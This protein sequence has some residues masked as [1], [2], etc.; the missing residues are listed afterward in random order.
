MVKK[1]TFIFLFYNIKD[2]DLQESYNSTV[3][4]N[5]LKANY[6]GEANIIIGE[7]IFKNLPDTTKRTFETILY[8]LKPDRLK[9]AWTKEPASARV[10][11]GNINIADKDVLGLVLLYIKLNYPAKDYIL[12]TNNHSNQFGALDYDQIIFK[13]G[14]KY[15]EL[16]KRDIVIKHIYEP[17][18]NVDMLSYYEL[19][20]AIEKGFLLNQFKQEKDL[21]YCLS[22]LIN[23]GC[24]SS[25]LDNLFHFSKSGD[26]NKN[27]IKYYCGSESRIANYFVDASAIINFIVDNGI[28]KG[29][30]LIFDALREIKDT[31]DP[32]EEERVKRTMFSCFEL[33]DSKVMNAF[34]ESITDLINKVIKDEDFKQVVKNIYTA[35]KDIAQIRFFEGDDLKNKY[36]IDFYSFL[37]FFAYNKSYDSDISKVKENYS[38]I[39]RFENCK[40][41]SGISCFI[42]PPELATIVEAKDIFNSMK[43]AY[44]DTA[45]VNNTFTQQVNWGE[46]I[47]LIIEE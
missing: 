7:T 38:K 1:F 32:K 22:L 45:N 39:I 3:I 19:S 4:G 21:D 36:S 17:N 34:F 18:E 29:V 2:Q 13:T 30:E 47:K 20:K 26:K 12:Y 14:L 25:T 23:I 33:S 42:P 35:Q 46:L 24:Y 15:I 11:F 6:T 8:K 16:F 9:I 40:D 37:D 28:E 41:F 5:L 44:F 10:N 27:L 31:Q 43:K